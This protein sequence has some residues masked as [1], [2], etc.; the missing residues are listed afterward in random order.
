MTYS[1]IVLPL[2]LT[3]SLLLSGCGGGG[4]STSPQASTLTKQEEAINHIASYAQDN[5]NPAPT[6]Q[7]YL[8]AG[9]RGVTAENIE[10]INTIVDSLNHD[11][12][13]T[14]NEIQ[15]IVDEISKNPEPTANPEPTV[16]QTPTANA[17]TDKSVTVN[18]TIVLNGSGQDSDGSI[19]SYEWREGNSVLSTSATFSYT[20][21]TVGTHTLTLTVTDD[22]GATASDSVVITVVE[23]ANQA[24]VANAGTDKS[25]TVNNTI[26]LNGSGQD[27]DGSIVSYEWREGNSVL[28][29][30]ATFSYTPTTVGTHILTLT[31]TDDDGATASDSVVI[32]VLEDKTIHIT[33][34]YQVQ[35]LEGGET[36]NIKVDVDTTT[37]KDLYLVFTN[38]SD[39]SRAS[40]EISQSKKLVN[41]SDKKVKNT[42]NQPNILHTPLAIQEFNKHLNIDTNKSNKQAKV[43]LVKNKSQEGDSHK[44]YIDATSS[45]DTTQ[46]TLRKIVSDVSTEF[47]NK[48]LNIW[49]SDDCF[50]SGSGCSKNDCVTQDMVD[51]LADTFLK[52]GSDNDIYDWVTNIVGEEWGSEA[53]AKYS[54]LIG[55]SNQVDILLTDIDNDNSSNGGVVGYFYSK[56]N[57]D[58]DT[59]SGSNERVMFYADAVLFAN[60]DDDWDIDDFWPKEM[61]ATLAHEFQHMIHFYQKTVLRTQNGTDTWINEMISETMEDVIATKIKHSGPRGVDYADGSAGYTNNPNGR[62]P[63]FNEN[64]TLSLT[65]WDGTLVDYAKVNAFGAYLTRN[66]GIKVLHDIVHNDYY[67]EDAVMYAIHQVAGYEDKTFDDI[68]AQWAVAVMLSDHTNLEN[69]PVYNIGDF[70]EDKYN[71]STYQL[72]SINFFNY[73]PTPNIYTSDSNVD[74]EPQGNLY[75]QV[76]Q[77]LDGSIDINLSVDSNI[78]VTLIAK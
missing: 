8:D 41:K 70:F 16:N 36:I 29:T 44:F 49:V 60:G 12:V 35:K 72:G 15:S 23:P 57:Y 42:L 66:F 69:V 27:S 19:V 39:S 62:Y 37:P 54:N 61:V 56:D 46:A 58:T 73:D 47:G 4:G 50:D 59:F 53:N 18:N 40:V 65:N 13:D 3:S 2:V 31:V 14:I 55:E 51:A 71:N 28:S 32:H 63:I 30:N 21:T 33:K 78:D 10:Q 43:F 1:N 22:D 68:L 45:G 5:H 48:T 64:N 34:D 52:D 67:H 20:P 77:D 25:V 75:Y 74:V 24:P 9:I 38:K 26:V 17:G 11:D 6:L 7:D 76:A